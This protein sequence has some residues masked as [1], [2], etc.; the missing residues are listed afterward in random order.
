[1]KTLPQDVA[2]LVFDLTAQKISFE[3]SWHPPEAL[4]LFSRG[5][6]PAQIEYFLHSSDHL[7]GWILLLGK[8]KMIIPLHF[9]LL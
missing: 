9:K 5:L 3:K 6:T 2:S 1:M 4:T 7:V 8:V